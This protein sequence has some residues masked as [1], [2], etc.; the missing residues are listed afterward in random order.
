MEDN[1][2]IENNAVE[3][4]NKKPKNNEEL[5]KVLCYLGIFILTLL[6]VLPPL[7]RVLFPEDGVTLEEVQS[8]VDLVCIK[9][10]DFVDYAITTTID[11]TYS[12]SEI[13]TATFTY[14]IEYD[15]ALFEGEEVIIEE[16][17][18]L[19]AIGGVEYDEGADSYTLYFDYASVDYS[20]EELLLDHQQ[21]LSDQLQYYTDQGFECETTE[22]E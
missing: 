20:S 19:K 8:V 2:N 9:T 21:L 6:I 7:F 16:Y 4:K 12:D 3:V 22:Y 1:K 17:E 15:Y 14:E 11:S 18:A 13:N 5:I 10:D